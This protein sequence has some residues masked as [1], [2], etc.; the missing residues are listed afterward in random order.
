MNEKMNTQWKDL[1]GIP[2]HTVLTLT[3]E[4]LPHWPAEKTWVFVMWLGVPYRYWGQA[5]KTAETI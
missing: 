4:V 3:A 1:D 2:D 5:V